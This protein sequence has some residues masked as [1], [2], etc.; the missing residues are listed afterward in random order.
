MHFLEDKT[1]MKST[2][3]QR[4]RIHK[5]KINK[6][7]IYC[8]QYRMTCSSLQFKFAIVE[9]DRIGYIYNNSVVPLLWPKFL[10]IGRLLQT[11]TV[12][13]LAKQQV[14]QRIAAT[15]FFVRQ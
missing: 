15:P 3:I 14:V 10:E 11:F 2:D 9:S 8:V 12:A 6:V 1:A 4:K 7:Y 13:R 5:N